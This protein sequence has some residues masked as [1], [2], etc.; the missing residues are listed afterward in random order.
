M[1]EHILDIEREIFWNYGNMTCAA[2]PLEHIDTI[3]ITGEINTNS[4]VYHV[5]YGVGFYFS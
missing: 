1:Y 3:S 4:V 5:I 2:Y